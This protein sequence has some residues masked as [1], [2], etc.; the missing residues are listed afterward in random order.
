MGGIRRQ[1]LGT[2]KRRDR[3]A[4]DTD[5]EMRDH[6]KLHAYVYGCREMQIKVGKIR[7]D[8]YLHIYIYIYTQMY[9]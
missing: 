3:L 1:C 9:I 4:Q 6:R 7:M 5:S 8:R 2:E